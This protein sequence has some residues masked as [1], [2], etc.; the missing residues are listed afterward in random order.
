MSLDLIPKARG[1]AHADACQAYRRLP[2]RGC[3]KT[4]VRNSKNR[5][6]CVIGRVPASCGSARNVVRVV[7]NRVGDNRVWRDKDFLRDD[8]CSA[9]HA[10]VNFVH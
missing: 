8:F 3:A 9:F 6:T 7:S 10:V 5:N 1:S 4:L 2:Q